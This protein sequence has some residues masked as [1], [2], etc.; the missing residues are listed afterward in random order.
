MTTS[1][2][3]NDPP[4]RRETGRVNQVNGVVFGINIEMVQSRGFS[5]TIAMSATA[6]CCTAI[7]SFPLGNAKYHNIAEI[8]TAIENATSNELIKIHVVFMGLRGLFQ[9]YRRTPMNV[10]GEKARATK[11]IFLAILRTSLL[12]S[13][14]CR[15]K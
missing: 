1:I 11:Y 13:K 2:K 14:C 15:D 10:I 8:I 7:H 6:P 9:E 3:L 4:S 12:K 5:D